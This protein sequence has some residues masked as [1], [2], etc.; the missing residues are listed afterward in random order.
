MQNG[1]GSDQ[2][3]GRSGHICLLPS[4]FAAGGGLPVAV[5]PP[6]TAGGAPSLAVRPLFAVGEASTDSLVFF[7]YFL[8]LFSV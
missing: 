4:L 6:F 2:I 1:G 8:I 3:C 5:R 7:F